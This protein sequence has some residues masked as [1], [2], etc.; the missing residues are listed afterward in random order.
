MLGAA[1]ISMGMNVRI[2]RK[3]LTTALSL[4]AILCG[5]APAGATTSTVNMSV[6]IT[7][8]AACNLSV[9]NI[10]FGSMLATA[11]LSAQTS[12]TAMG[13]LLTYTCSPGSTTP[14]LTY[15][16]GSNYSSGSNRMKGTSSDYIPYTLTMPT[17]T[18]F[19][20]V[21]QTAQIYANIAAQTTLPT[22]DVYTD[23]VVLTLT[24]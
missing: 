21:A 17:I 5:T 4:A 12:T 9:T 23:T 10:N 20:G 3:H 11:L 2:F 6:G 15:G 18:A 14:V 8:T 16:Q 13:G 7:I 1:I 22:V 19:T 24:Y